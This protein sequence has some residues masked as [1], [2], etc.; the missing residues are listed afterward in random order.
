MWFRSKK[1]RKLRTRG[2]CRHSDYYI[3]VVVDFF[4]FSC[5]PVMTQE[6]VFVNEN[7]FV[8]HIQKSWDTVFLLLMTSITILG[9]ILLSGNIYGNKTSVSSV[10]SILYQQLI[11]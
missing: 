10:S 3:L 1:N 2:F 4:L 5:E 8:L 6:N 9:L 7:F 11:F